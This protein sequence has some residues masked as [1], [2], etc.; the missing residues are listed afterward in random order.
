MNKSLKKIFLPLLILTVSIALL[1]A[2]SGGSGDAE[3]VI[4]KEVT[5]TVTLRV[6]GYEDMANLDA[7][8]INLTEGMTALDA[9]YTTDFVIV[10]SD[11]F[12]TSVDGLKNG[13][14]GYPYSGW[15]YLVNGKFA[16]VGASEYVLKD[17]DTVEWKY[18][19][20]FE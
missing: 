7:A 8:E 5:G 6:S 16:E 10:A 3:D 18:S 14:D 11:G 17:G 9:L 13:T 12:V 2:C 4:E 20:T 19:L 1:A 15:T